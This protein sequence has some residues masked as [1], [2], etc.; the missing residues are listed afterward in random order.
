MVQ[1]YTSF[2]DGMSKKSA[3]SIGNYWEFGNRQLE[4]IESLGTN[5]FTGLEHFNCCRD[6]EL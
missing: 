5:E 3:P 4:I 6:Y 2:D 1:L